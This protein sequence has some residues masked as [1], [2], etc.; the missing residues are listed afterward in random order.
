[1]K[2]YTITIGDETENIIFDLVRFYAKTTG[3]NSINSQ[4]VVEQA[5][6][7]GLCNK[8]NFFKMNVDVP[9]SIKK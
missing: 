6:R 8:I 9:D 4:F 1:M 2:T 3:S 7:D 5:I